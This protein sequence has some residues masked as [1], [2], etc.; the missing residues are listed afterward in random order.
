MAS[1][2]PRSPDTDAFWQAFRRHAGLDHDNCV[3][4]SFGDSPEMATE[5]A[6]LVMA[7]MK[8]ATASLARDYGE[9][10][11][12][13]PRPGDFVLV[14][15]GEGCP[16]FIWRTTEL[17]IKPLSEVDEAFAWDEGEGDRTRDWWLA[18]H[19]RYF[20]RQASREGFEFDDNIL[21]A[22]ERFEVV[23]LLDI[24]HTI[25]EPASPYAL[26]ER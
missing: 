17:T 23:W 2:P 22:F 12:P 3:V 9:D 20:G 11:E 13:I 1:M 26:T 6:D 25:R 10:R 16:R 18:A 5:L 19:R 14:V 24:A 7:R 8:R 4:A 21:T 15:D